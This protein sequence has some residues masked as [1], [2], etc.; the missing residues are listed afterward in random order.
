MK[1]PPHTPV[2]SFDWTQFTRLVHPMQVAIVEALL[3][4]GKPLSAK[5]FSQLFA[6]QI[7]HASAKTS[8]MS[9]HVREL[10]K[11]GVLERTGTESVRGAVRRF[12]FITGGR[13][14]CR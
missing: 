14:Q 12:Y 5:D 6:G 10:A 3:W 8:Y 7:A 1:P 9:Y 11:V 2:E 4:I 13:P